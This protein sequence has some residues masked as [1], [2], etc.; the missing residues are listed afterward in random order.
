M[1]LTINKQKS[2][3]IANIFNTQIQEFLNNRFFKLNCFQLDCNAD[4]ST[5]I[6]KTNTNSSDILDKPEKIQLMFNIY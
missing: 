1:G 2:N 4:K 3:E 5:I 6:H